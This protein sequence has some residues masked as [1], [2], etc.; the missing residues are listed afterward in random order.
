MKAHALE[1][2]TNKL[3]MAQRQAVELRTAAEARRA[4]AANRAARKAEAMKTHG[5]FINLLFLSYLCT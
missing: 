1:K 5:K 4:K 3:A 2:L